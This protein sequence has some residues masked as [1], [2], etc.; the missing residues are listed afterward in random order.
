MLIG[1]C[2]TNTLCHSDQLDEL[3]VTPSG[4]SLVHC[5]SLVFGL[6]SKPFR[7]VTA[8]LPYLTLQINCLSTILFD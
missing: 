4:E 7:I 5:S 6:I 8:A 3:H 1:C 2:N